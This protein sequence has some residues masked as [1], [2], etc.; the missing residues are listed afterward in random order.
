MKIFETQKKLEKLEC[1]LQLIP[2]LVPGH[3]IDISTKDHVTDITEDNSHNTAADHGAEDQSIQ[4]RY[5][6][7][8]GNDLY[9]FGTK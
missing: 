4:I 7:I 1:Q 2:D 3:V 5:V 8:M 6:N 9:L